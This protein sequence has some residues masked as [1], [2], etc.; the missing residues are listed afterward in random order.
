MYHFCTYFD[1]RYLT[2][3]LALYDSLA[4][5]GHEFTLWVLAFD[6][7]AERALA[8]SGRPG[9]RVVPI[10]VLEAADAELL[11][12]KATRSLVEYFWTCTSAWTH[13]LL[14]EHADIELLT[15][16]DADTWFF[17]DYADLLAAVGRH[18][19]AITPHDFS[20]H[21]RHME[22]SGRYN[23]SWVSFRR[24]EAGLACVAD[25]R[26]K[27]IAWCY[28]RHE[29]GRFG[30][31]KYLDAWPTDF[32]NVL[33]IEHPGVN[34][35]P[36]NLGSRAVRFASGQGLTANGQPLVFYHFHNLKR[37]RSWLYDASVDN[38][39]AP[40][41]ATLRRQVYRPYVA[42][43]RALEQSLPADLRASSLGHLK[44]QD[45]RSRCPRPL[46]PLW[47]TLKM[48]ARGQAVTPWR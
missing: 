4:G 17:S 37:V 44:L 10:R 47:W 41:T 8:Q 11:A 36:W 5:F 12:A 6:E 13:Y 7:T 33:V 15:Y 30:D 1:A 32:A 20:P 2:R 35:A 9:I 29:E 14:Q 39:Q 22:K 31:Q 42:K 16:I 46:R 18:S 3:G 27:C 38:Y 40:F 28:H 34:V 45:V 19:I 48:L 43:L 26:R 24:D 25:W 23:V 21:L